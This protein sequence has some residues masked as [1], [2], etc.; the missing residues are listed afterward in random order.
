MPSY[1]HWERHPKPTPT[2]RGSGHHGSGRGASHSHGPSGFHVRPQHHYSSAEQ[3]TWNA[4]GERG[5]GA[6][7]MKPQPY[8]FL[9]VVDFECTCEDKQP[10]YP[11]EII[12]FPCVGFNTATLEIAGEFHSFVRPV[13]RLQLTPFCVELT[14]VTQ[15]DVDAAP[16]L[17]DVVASFEAWVLKTFPA[18]AKIVLATDGPYD[19]R[20]F[21]HRGAVLRDKNYASTFFYRYVDIRTTFNKYL[22]IHRQMKLEKMLH[23]VGLKFEGRP[24]CGQD[25][26]RNIARLAIELMHRGCIF[27]FTSVIAMASEPERRHAYV[28]PPWAEQEAQ[29]VF[30]ASDAE[31]ARRAKSK[32]WLVLLAVLSLLVTLCSIW[33]T[34]LK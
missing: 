24:H 20:T 11:H 1:T 32:L 26:T 30:V 10:N 18:G 4:A 31:E 33:W 19:L 9:L 23:H 5:E 27:N 22:R 17:R 21:F 14:G 16:V 15:E 3:G 8:Q 25:D 12:E 29:E 13:R 7:R 6:S 34:L 2:S 28:F